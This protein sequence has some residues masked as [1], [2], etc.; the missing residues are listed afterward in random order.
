MLISVHISEN[1]TE[2]LKYKTNH[3]FHCQLF[4]FLSESNVCY[5]KSVITCRGLLNVHES[6]KSV[7][8][9]R[10]RSKVH[11]QKM[12][13][14]FLEIAWDFTLG[15]SGALQHGFIAPLCLL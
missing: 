11:I 3:Q 5:L 10:Q 13:P 15:N 2:K 8:F 9:E 12:T 6:N 7:V 14:F 4:S 1:F